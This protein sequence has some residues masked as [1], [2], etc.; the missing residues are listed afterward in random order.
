MSK[1]N[2]EQRT[3]EQSNL[4]RWTELMTIH[5]AHYDAHYDAHFDVHYDAHY[6]VHYDGDYDGDYDAHYDA[7]FNAHY[8]GEWKA[9]G[10]RGRKRL[11]RPSSQSHCPR[12]WLYR[13]CRRWWCTAR[14]SPDTSLKRKGNVH[15]HSVKWSDVIKGPLEITFPTLLHDQTHW[16]EW[17]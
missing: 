3:K 8:E 10:K 13:T 1:Q 2:L 6:D 12:R 7:H 9:L 5:D 4:T 14:S 16:A 17:D 15:K 11:T